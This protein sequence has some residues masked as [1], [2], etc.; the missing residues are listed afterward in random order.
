MAPRKEL[1]VPSNSANA[2][3]GSTIF[4]EE[5]DFEGSNLRLEAIMSNQIVQGTL[6]KQRR[7]GNRSRMA[8]TVII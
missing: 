2:A 5:D 1:K 6:L 8:A 4:L 7:D 3:T